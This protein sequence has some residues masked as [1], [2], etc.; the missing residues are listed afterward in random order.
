MCV[1]HTYYASAWHKN[2]D[3]KIMNIIFWCQISLGSNLFVIFEDTR[4]VESIQTTSFD[5][6]Y[7]YFHSSSFS[8]WYAGSQMWLRSLMIADVSFFPFDTKMDHPTIPSRCS[9]MTR[10]LEKSS[11]VL[12]AHGKTFSL[13]DV[14]KDGFMHE[15]PA[16]RIS[17]DSRETSSFKSLHAAPQWLVTAARSA[18]WIFLTE[19]FLNMS[20]DNKSFISKLCIRTMT[21]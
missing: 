13:W 20:T 14:L 19:T 21:C 3:K 18:W 12:W 5:L 2:L 4:R 8:G 10:S 9:S 15:D 11:L 1:Q 6:Q 16:W 17:W 7:W